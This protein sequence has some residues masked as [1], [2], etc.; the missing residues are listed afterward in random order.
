ML[1]QQKQ[2][3][4]HSV[5]GVICPRSITPNLGSLPEYTGWKDTHGRIPIKPTERKNCSGGIHVHESPVANIVWDYTEQ[6]W[7]STK[8]SP[9][10]KRKAKFILKAIPHFCFY[11]K[12]IGAAYVEFMGPTQTLLR[13]Q[14]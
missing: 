8:T 7:E 5:T 13:A 1:C 10:A 14:F 4:S 2:K 9:T 12:N 11:L 6:K 3:K